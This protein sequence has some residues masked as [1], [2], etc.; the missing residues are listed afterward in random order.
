MF[1]EILLTV[2][3]AVLIAAVPVVTS[4]LCLYL[5][6]KRDEVLTKTGNVVVK[7]LIQEACDAVVTAVTYTNQTYVDVLKKSDKFTKENQQEAF[8][9]AYSVALNTM[10]TEAQEYIDTTYDSLQSWLTA[11]IEAEVKA[12]K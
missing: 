9:M 11:K 2:L 5:K 8:K 3:Q 10:S 12:Q 1:K 6:G 7:T 4:Y